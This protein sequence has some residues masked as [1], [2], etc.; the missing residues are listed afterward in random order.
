MSLS[1]H[2]PPMNK[3]SQEI[4]VQL[5]AVLAAAWL[6][7]KVPAFKAIVSGNTLSPLENPPV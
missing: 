1:A 5:V 7:S 4:I 6:I 3:I 2:L